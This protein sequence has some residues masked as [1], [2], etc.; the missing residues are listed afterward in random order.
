MFQNFDFLIFFYIR[1]N[2][3]ILWTVLQFS[4]WK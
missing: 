1:F 4:K 3:L 2:F